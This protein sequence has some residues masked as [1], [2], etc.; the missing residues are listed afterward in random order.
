[1]KACH[2]ADDG[3]I[4]AEAAVS[5]NL[6]PVR[7]DALNVVEGVR[8]LRMASQFRLF[9]GA[10]MG[11]YLVTQRLD[12]VI[13]LLDL[14]PGAIVLSRYGLQ[15]RDLLLDFVEL[16]LRF[17]SRVHLIAVPIPSIPASFNHRQ[18]KLR[19]RYHQC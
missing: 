13:Q 14:L 5:V 19:T 6:A 8:T 10:E 1:M 16:L 9:P 4:V 11:V 7:E 15:F 3:G 17:Y 2:S 18:Q 12:A